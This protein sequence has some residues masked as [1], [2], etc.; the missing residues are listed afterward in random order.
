MQVPFKVFYATI[1]GEPAAWQADTCRPWYLAMV[2]DRSC[3]SYLLRLELS[4]VEPI[5]RTD[6]TTTVH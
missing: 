3:R 6:N 4:L 1:P 5:E 2:V